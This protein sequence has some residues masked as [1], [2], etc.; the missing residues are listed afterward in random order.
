MQV[1]L[2]RLAEKEFV[3]ASRYFFND[4]PFKHE[5]FREEVLTVLERIRFNPNIGAPCEKGHRWMRTKRFKYIRYYKQVTDELIMVYAV[6]H[7]SRRPGY[8]L[9]RT[10]RP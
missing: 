1:I 3:N 10:K 8:W 6:A 5:R 4:H 7:A 9:R 2:H